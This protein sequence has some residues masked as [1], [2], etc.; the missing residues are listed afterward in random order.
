M[1]ISKERYGYDFGSLRVDKEML[2]NFQNEPTLV[3][4]IPDEEQQTILEKVAKGIVRRQLTAPA[5]FFFEICKPL[6]FIGSQLLYGVS[7]FVQ[8]FLKGNEYKKFSLIIEKDENVERLI[9]L[10]EKHNQ[11]ESE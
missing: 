1:L 4:D 11:E 10:I 7:P 2:N 5:I 9:R 3:D 8:A 6:N